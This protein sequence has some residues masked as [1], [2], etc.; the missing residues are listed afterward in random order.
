MHG[1]LNAALIASTPTCWSKL[2]NFKS[3]NFLA[4]YKSAVPPPGTMPSSRAALVAQSASFNRSFT[5]LTSTSLAPP[6]LITA[7]PPASLANR[8]LSLS[9]SY[10]EVVASMASRIASHRSSILAFSPA[11]SSITVSSFVIVT[12]LIWPSCVICRSSSLSPSSSLSSCVPVSTAKSWRIALR[13]SPKPGAFTAATLRPPRNLLTM[14]IARASPSMSSAITSSGFWT[15]ATC[16]KM[17]R[18]LCT[19]EIFFS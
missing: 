2:S 15:L 10:S 6:T 4:A 3:S 5:S 8:S 18:M 12:V 1:W 11:P 9:F 16:S 14:S 7:T 17:G 19:D 13:L